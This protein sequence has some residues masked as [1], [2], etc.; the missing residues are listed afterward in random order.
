MDL[1][2][3]PEGTVSRWQSCDQQRCLLVIGGIL[4]R[5]HWPH[6]AR[7]LQSQ[8]EEG[9][10]LCRHMDGV[11][12][13][14]DE[15]PRGA[16]GRLLAHV[17]LNGHGSYPTAGFIPRNL[18][19]FNDY[20]S[21]QGAVWDPVSVSLTLMCLHALMVSFHALLVLPIRRSVRSISNRQ[22]L[23]G[24]NNGQRP[25]WWRAASGCCMRLC[26]TVTAAPT[27]GSQGKGGRPEGRRRLSAG[28]HHRES[29][30]RFPC[31][32]AGQSGDSDQQRAGRA[33]AVCG[34]QRAGAERLVLPI[35]GQWA[36]CAR[37]ESVSM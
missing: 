23:S 28:H 35:L 17:A 26:K 12:R 19:A 3:I 21:N 25:H 20:T 16:D 29:A 36:A 7:S 4:R 33:A 37:S 9:I 14:A 27:S 10:P 15:A 1:T 31:A 11:W 34:G 18:L 32:P 5:R 6:V 2:Y 30:D 24:V 13:S 22:S 8:A